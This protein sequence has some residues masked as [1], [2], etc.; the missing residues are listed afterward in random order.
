M[1]L[2]FRPQL[3]VGGAAPRSL[4]LPG[5]AQGFSQAWRPSPLV[6]SVGGRLV[7]NLPRLRILNPGWLLYAWALQQVAREFTW[8]LAFYMNGLQFIRFCAPVGASGFIGPANLPNCTTGQA[9]GGD[10]LGDLGKKLKGAYAAGYIHIVGQGNSL[11]GGVPRYNSQSIFYWPGLT[12]VGL[13][14][15]YYRSA[16]LPI[17]VGNNYAPPYASYLR[18]P[19]GFVM[20]QVRPWP[21]WAGPRP[22]TGPSPVPQAPDYP[23]QGTIAGPGT[24]WDW[25]PG[26]SR[27]IVRPIPA[28]PSIPRTVPRTNVREMK[29]GANTRAAGLFFSLMKAREL[30]SEWGD[31]LDVIFKSLPKSTQKAFGGSNASTSRKVQAVLER[32]G[33][34][35]AREFLKN[36]IANHIEDEIIGR[37]YMK[38]R[39]QARAGIVGN[40][41][42]SIG[43]VANDAFKNYAK[44]VSNLSNDLADLVMDGVDEVTNT[45]ARN[46]NAKAAK[47]DAA[48]ERYRTLDPAL[49]AM[50]KR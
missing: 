42:G 20:P 27:P 41:M 13:Q 17:R 22:T 45:Q 10:P 19:P 5:L 12:A 29:I 31:L 37:T 34:M 48:F 15:P 46:I 14:R 16:A 18:Q 44:Y 4:P 50:A 1:S 6:R 35:D 36:L 43:P 2:P 21:V 28:N 8:Q 49:T 24:G 32:F 23:D 9:W 25:N 39:S 26:V 33:D 47:A 30:V 7:P 40:Q 3:A 11:S 38:W